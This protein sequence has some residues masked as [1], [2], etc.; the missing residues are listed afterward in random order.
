MPIKTQKTDG[1]IIQ[2]AILDDDLV[3]HTRLM[4]PERQ[5]ILRHNAELRRN[6]E[7]WKKTDFGMRTELSIPEVDYILL[8]RKYP[9][10]GS[11][12]AHEKTLAWQE[13]MRSSECDPY[14]VRDKK[15][16]VRP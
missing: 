2:Q 11:K 4:Q 8:L 9:K 7:A 1:T 5:A 3:L 15:R 12:N 13:F 14:R 6:P 10:L 16:I